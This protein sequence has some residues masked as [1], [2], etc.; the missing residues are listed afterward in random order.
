MIDIKVFRKAKKGTATVGGGTSVVVTGRGTGSDGQVAKEALHAYAADRAT[1]ADEATYAQRAGVAQRADRLSDDSETWTELAELYLRKTVEDVAQE[2]I[3]FVKGLWVKA[4]GLFGIDASGNATLNDVSASGSVTASGG[5]TTPQAG[6]SGFERGLLGAGWRV[7]TDDD[8]AH[9]EV[10][11]ATIR[12]KLEVMEI[13]VRKIQYSSGSLMLGHA[14]GKVVAV[15]MN[16]QAAESLYNYGYHRL[17]LKVTDGETTIKN[18]WAVG[19]M[20][21]CQEF[22]R[23]SGNRTYH[24]LVIGTGV[25]ELEGE[26]HIYIDVPSNWNRLITFVYDEEAV[27]WAAVA[28][29]GEEETFTCYSARSDDDDRPQSGDSVAQVGNVFDVDRQT[30]TVLSSEGGGGLYIYAGIGSDCSTV[31]RQYNLSSHLTEC[32]SPSRTLIQADSINLKAGDGAYH[33]VNV[34]RGTWTSGTTAYANEEWSY[35]GSVWL[36][37][38]ASGTTDTPSTTSS[39]WEQVVA[40][41]ADGTQ[42]PSGVDGVDGTSFVVR[43]TAVGIYKS[44][45]TVPSTPPVS[46]GIYLIES[47]AVN[48]YDS[49]TFASAVERVANGGTWVHSGTA[50]TGYARKLELSDDAADGHLFVCNA[51]YGTW[52]DL[53]DITGT[54]G[55]DGNDGKDGLTFG[56]TPST[57]IVVESYVK[58]WEVGDTLG[59]DS[60]PAYDGTPQYTDSAGYYLDGDGGSRIAVY[61]YEYPAAVGLSVVRGD[62]VLYTGTGYNVTAVSASPSTGLSASWGGN[63]LLV[64]VSRA[65]AQSSHERAYVSVSVL[66]DGMTY[67]LTL[68]VL[69]TRSGQSYVR[70]E[71]GLAEVAVETVEEAID[72]AGI[73][74]TSNWQSALTITGGGSTPISLASWVDGAMR[75]GLQVK[76]S[77]DSYWLEFTGDSFK[78]LSQN[79]LKMFIE[80]GLLKFPNPSDT[81]KT[82]I[83]FGV[84]SGGNSVLTYYDGDGNALY[85]LGPEG[86]QFAKSQALGLRTR[87]MAAISYSGYTFNTQAEDLQVEAYAYIVKFLKQATA[88]TGI[89]SV[90]GSPAWQLLYKMSVGQYVAVSAGEQDFEITDLDGDG[91]Y[92]EALTLSSDLGASLGSLYDG[93]WCWDELIATPGGAANIMANASYKYMGGL[94]IDTDTRVYDR[95]TAPSDYN[96]IRNETTISSDHQSVYYPWTVDFSQRVLYRTLRCYYQGV[97]LYAVRVFW[98]G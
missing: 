96:S 91:T 85:N 66:V 64:S 58:D 1:F 22:N 38:A 89:Q 12:R 51:D 28:G 70:L 33:A 48:A 17:W 50:Q 2:A 4:Q 27:E 32:I 94:Y 95:T 97:E 40:K 93:K 37:T 23:N 13:D 79:I 56:F 77:G 52:T 39:D 34:Y 82:Q 16:R 25:E 61:H 45:E 62:T 69:I 73:V 90:S 68:P 14:G 54:D 18:E 81:T 88:P 83:A 55:V 30:L 63:A 76:H 43:G 59:T 24:V 3:G 53:G 46:D 44:G 92:T 31:G 80:D 87:L 72:D 78:F 42:G 29:T 10:D 9:L 67:A 71:R 98:N 20:V 21:K 60:Y 57:A 7:W 35:N 5:V 75:A 6:S 49:S 8:G 11:D 65:M 36:C 47:G 26:D 86:L 84:D 74:T 41:G 19:D 15:E